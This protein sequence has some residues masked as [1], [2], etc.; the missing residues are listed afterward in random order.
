MSIFILLG[1]LF[2]GVPAFILVII[3]I[4][5]G[6]RTFYE[7]HYP[8]EVDL[9]IPCLVIIFFFLFGCAVVMV[10]M[11]IGAIIGWLIGISLG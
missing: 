10:S 9:P 1:A 2:L 8:R 6:A 7:K 5:R 4:I 3:F 11:L